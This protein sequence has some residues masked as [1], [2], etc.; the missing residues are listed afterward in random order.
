MKKSNLYFI[1]MGNGVYIPSLSLEKPTPNAVFVT[2][3]G[4][5]PTK[6]KVIT[7]D[8]Y[9]DTDTFEISENNRIE[10]MSE[11]TEIGK[12]FSFPLALWDYDSKLNISDELGDF[13][14]NSYEVKTNALRGN[15]PPYM[16]YLKP[17]KKDTYSAYVSYNYDYKDGIFLMY[18][19]KY[20]V[21]LTSATTNILGGIRT[22]TY[23]VRNREELIHKLN[24][25]GTW[26]VYLSTVHS[27]QDLSNC[28]YSYE[29]NENYELDLLYRECYK[30]RKEIQHEAYSLLDAANAE[31]A[32]K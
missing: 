15:K 8:A 27:D 30:R 17:G 9:G 16:V 22:Y 6:L 24:M 5:Y 29:N 1:P 10:L 23:T 13:L 4:D 7:H 21:T 19:P 11:L 12:S 2:Q 28:V 14:E 32:D 20:P 25:F 26:R 18:E 3:E 31:K